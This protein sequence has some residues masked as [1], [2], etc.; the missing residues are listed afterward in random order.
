MNV[1]CIAYLTSD[2]LE[3]IT[4]RFAEE[5][6]SL[7]EEHRRKMDEYLQRKRHSLSASPVG[8]HRLSSSTG[9][10]TSANI[11]ARLK[12][13]QHNNFVTI[14][15]TASG[16]VPYSS[17]P[18]LQHQYHHH[19]HHNAGLTPEGE[20]MERKVKQALMTE[21]TTKPKPPSG[22][23]DLSPSTRSFQRVDNSKLNPKS[24]VTSQ[25]GHQGSQGSSSMS[26]WPGEDFHSGLNEMTPEPP[27]IPT[28]NKPDISEFDPI[29]TKNK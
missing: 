6:R 29:E 14:P 27:N 10:G 7:K 22:K 24:T 13:Q 25:Q 18:H 8:N 23:S 4:I 9:S 16:Q 17:Q 5:E 2:T 20:N 12:Q 26:T 3:F 11:K 15:T 19:Q 1:K 28:T 21:F